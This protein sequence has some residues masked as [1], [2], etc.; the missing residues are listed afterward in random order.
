MNTNT[1]SS[2]RVVDARGVTVADIG[3]MFFSSC[4]VAEYEE[5]YKAYISVSIVRTPATERDSSI[6]EKVL[7]AL[8]YAGCVD[9][10]GGIDGTPI[11]WLK[12]KSRTDRLA[13]GTLSPSGG[14]TT[15]SVY[16]PTRIETTV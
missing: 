11:L 6:V 7:S 8:I 3:D 14:V 9:S 13:F 2:M 1:H 15:F 12:D 10:S 4:S 16:I 5:W